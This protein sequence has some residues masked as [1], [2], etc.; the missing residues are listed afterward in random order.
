MRFALLLCLLALPARAEISEAELMRDFEIAF[1][2]TC[3]YLY[4][5]LG[6]PPP[7]QHWDLTVTEPEGRQRTARLWQVPCTLHAHN[8]DDLFFMDGLDALGFAVPDLQIV[9]EN[10]QDPLSKVTAITVIGWR[11]ET[12]LANAVFDPKTLTL[13]AHRDLGVADQFEEAR[14]LLIDGHFRLI[15]YAVDADADALEQALTVYAA[16]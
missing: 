14:Y 7:P 12:T 9:R 8:A 10:P 16:P 6:S 15:H 11:T 1:D 5:S 13:T 2:T 4:D 3:G